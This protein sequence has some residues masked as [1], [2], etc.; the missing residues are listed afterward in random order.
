MSA[1]I[2]IVEDERITAEDLRDILTN[3]D[4]SV[5]ASVS[6]GADAIALAEETQP[7]LALMD[8][9]IKGAMDG[10]E[11]ARVL[12]ERFNI[13]VIFLTAHAD[14]GTVSRAKSAAPLGYIVKPFQ[15]S[16]LHASI[17]IALHKHGVD[18]Q[19]L[20][21]SE[22]FASTLRA[23]SEGVISVDRGESVTFL[24][25]AAEGWTGWT[26]REAMGRQL[27]EVFPL[28]DAASG[29][30]VETPLWRA[31]GEG[32]LDELGEGILLMHRNGNRRVIAGSIAP[33]HDHRGHVSGAVVL[34]GRALGDSRILPIKAGPEEDEGVGAGGF[35]MVAASTA[36]KQVLRFARR[37]AESEVSTILI[38]GESGTGKDVIA[39]FIH[40]FGRRSQGP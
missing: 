4:Y 7:D 24:N 26:A 22:L 16:E 27:R 37:V 23:I 6:N 17:A 35:K 33:I 28:I 31:L 21:K 5:V 14:S 19:S 32:S 34:F 25:P 13:P 8:I 11:T 20:G 18:L 36:M 38:E 30:G 2:L 15:E 1:R 9:Q 29:E 10:T 40:H 3:L 39:Q 12:R